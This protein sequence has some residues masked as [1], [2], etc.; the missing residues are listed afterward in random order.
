MKRALLSALALTVAI[1]TMVNAQKEISK[2]WDYMGVATD[3]TT[4]F[5]HEKSRIGNQVVMEIRVVD[6]PDTYDKD[7]VLTR[8]INCAKG[9]V[10]S[11]DQWEKPN[12]N[13]IWNMWIRY[14]CP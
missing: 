4:Y 5:A 2:N 14:A 3:G 13:S 8:G 11:S 6:D 10:K 7:F 1:P 9:L 12:P